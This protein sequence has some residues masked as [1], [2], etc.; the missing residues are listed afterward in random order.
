MSVN[1]S[2]SALDAIQ[3]ILSVNENQDTEA[4]FLERGD[5]GMQYEPPELRG[6]H[7]RNLTD[8]GKSYQLEVHLARR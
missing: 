3:N 4:D 2:G 6:P 7:E 5:R 1:G 8:K